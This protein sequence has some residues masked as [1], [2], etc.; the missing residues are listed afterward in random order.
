MALHTVKV[1][2]K[3]RGKNYFNRMS[4]HHYTKYLVALLLTQD[5]S[6][7]RSNNLFFS[8]GEDYNELIAV[9]VVFAP[10][11][12]TQTVTLTALNDSVAEGDETLTATITTAQSGV[13]IT[14]PQANITI[15]E[16]VGRHNTHTHTN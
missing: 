13:D 7:I 11:V 6:L 9:S 5:G 14:V 12:S 4:W 8:G 10:G 3:L 2:I 16:I 15:L 1:V